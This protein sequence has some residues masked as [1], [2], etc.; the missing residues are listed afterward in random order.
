MNHTIIFNEGLSYVD[1]IKRYNYSYETNNIIA[2]ASEE[3]GQLVPKHRGV[4]Y[5]DFTI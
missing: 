4:R 5:N 2:I 1:I 3:N